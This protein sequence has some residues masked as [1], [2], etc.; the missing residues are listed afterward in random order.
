MPSPYTP[1][2]AMFAPADP[3][4]KVLPCPP[5]LSREASSKD[6]S[7]KLLWRIRPKL[8]GPWTT[9]NRVCYPQR[10][11]NNPTQPAR[12]SATRNYLWSILW[13]VLWFPSNRSMGLR[14]SSNLRSSW[15]SPSLRVHDR[16]WTQTECLQGPRRHPQSS[17]TQSAV[18]TSILVDFHS[19]TS[20]VS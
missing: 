16:M 13:L 15:W 1:T 3:L 11:P 12:E 4:H 9:R 6:P 17:S 10:H 2:Q 5:N 7:P 19:Y 20:S 14:P 18:N 8:A